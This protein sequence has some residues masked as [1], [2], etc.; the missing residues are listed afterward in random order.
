MSLNNAEINTLLKK[1]ADRYEEYAEKYNPT[2]F[3]VKAFKER[4]NMTVANK[5]NLESFLLAEITNFENI[6]NK[7]DKKKNSKSFTQKVEAMFEENLGKIKKYPA[8]QFNKR[9]GIEI[10]HL[11]GAISEY[12]KF[13]LPVVRVLV[14]DA[15]YKNRLNTFDGF[16]SS[17]SQQTGSDKLAPL[18]EDHYLILERPRISELEIEKNK[19]V[20]MKECAF[21]LHD[22]IDFLD[23]IIGLGAGLENPLKFD[24]LYVNE[25]LRKEIIKNYSQFT[26]FGALFK[27]S[28]DAKAIL[29][30]FRL[31]S[32]KRTSATSRNQY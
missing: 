10:V 26:G 15:S 30:D 22:F 16:F 4:L 14:K 13:A 19:A 20:Y 18:I 17:V 6:K 9:A 2:W 7:Y 1:L 32:F 29:D 11:Y 23:D 27:L 31:T 21:I 25:S 8:I 12:Q 5:M 3:N 28:E 24:G